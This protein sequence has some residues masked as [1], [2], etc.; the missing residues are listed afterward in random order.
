[1]IVN[2]LFSLL[3]RGNFYRYSGGC[4]YSG[5]ISIDTQGVVVTQG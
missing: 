3:L 1:M 5:V 2:T 4:S